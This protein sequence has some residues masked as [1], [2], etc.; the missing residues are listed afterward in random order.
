M[1]TARWL[2]YK[3]DVDPKSLVAAGGL[4]LK[5]IERLSARPSPTSTQTRSSRRHGGMHYHKVHQSRSG[6]GR[7]SWR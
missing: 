2:E 6:C 3:I 5:A 7:A 4:D 1:S